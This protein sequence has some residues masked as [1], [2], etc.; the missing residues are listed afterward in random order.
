MTP[1]DHNKTVGI[2]HLVYGGFMVLMMILFS[3]FFLG[4]FGLAM[5]NQPD[6]PPAIFMIFMVAILFFF[7]VVLAIPSFIAGWALLKRKKSAKIL[8]IIAGVVAAMSFPLGT[9]LCVY[10]LWF[11]FGENGRILYDNAAAALPPPPPVWTTDASAQREK[12]YVP[13][14]PPDWR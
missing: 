8:G 3:T 10:T 6:A 13:R 14:T 2:L 9:A 5:A 11:L 1:K 7:Y 12:A 4:L